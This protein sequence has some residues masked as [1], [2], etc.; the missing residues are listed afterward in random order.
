M[1]REGL[2]NLWVAYH[3]SELSSELLSKN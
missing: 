1:I 3:P 2:L